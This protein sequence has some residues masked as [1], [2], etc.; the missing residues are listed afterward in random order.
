MFRF[1]IREWMLM[2]LV[3][4]ILVAWWL[5]RSFL[6]NTVSRQDDQIFRLRQ[7]E[8]NYQSNKLL[9]MKLPTIPTPAPTLRFPPDTDYQAPASL[10][11]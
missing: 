1:S 10:E 7:Q 2:T 11:E 8:S 3:V 4:A 5:E 9:L 6:K